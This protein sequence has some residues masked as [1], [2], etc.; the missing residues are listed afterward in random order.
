MTQPRG[1]RGR[2]VA[3]PAANPWGLT[4]AEENGMDAVIEHGSVVNAARELG[5]S[6]NTLKYQILAAKVKIGSHAQDRNSISH[7][8]LWDRYRR[9]RS[10]SEAGLAL[11]NAWR[12]VASEQEV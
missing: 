2:F 12:F 3:E 8:I 11:Q 1:T 7:F 6:H 5:I 4:E 9:E 10:R